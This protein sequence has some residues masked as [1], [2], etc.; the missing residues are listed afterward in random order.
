ML[1]THSPEKIKILSSFSIDNVNRI[2]KLVETCGLI[3]CM[4]QMKLSLPISCELYCSVKELLM[5]NKITKDAIA[6]DLAC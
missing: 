6:D 4:G 2:W 3:Y 5:N 1:D